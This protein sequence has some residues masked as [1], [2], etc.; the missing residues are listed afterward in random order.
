MSSQSLP[1]RTSRPSASG[2]V[3]AASAS[4]TEQAIGL[5]IARSCGQAHGADRRDMFSAVD[6]AAEA[7]RLARTYVWWQEPAV[8]LADTASL[9]RQILRLGRPEDYVLASEIWGEE[10]LRCALV[11]ARPGEID[12]KSEH[13]WRLRFGFTAGAG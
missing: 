11:E 12:P 4:A 1:S 5:S 10:A 6:R 7:E 9:L 8:T 2:S 3:I 13:F